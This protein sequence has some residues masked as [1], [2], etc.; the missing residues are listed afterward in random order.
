MIPGLAEVAQ[1]FAL[2]PYFV[3]LGLAF[4]LTGILVSLQAVAGW[5]EHHD[6]S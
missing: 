3:A 6:P 1:R 5:F 2:N 4:L